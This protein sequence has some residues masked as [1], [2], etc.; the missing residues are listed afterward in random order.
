[1]PRASGLWRPAV[2]RTS[3]RFLPQPPAIPGYL[4]ATIDVRPAAARAAEAVA[5]VVAVHVDLFGVVGLDLDPHLL[6]E[7]DPD[8]P[9]GRLHLVAGHLGLGDDPGEPGGGRCRPGALVASDAA[10]QQAADGQHP[11]DE[12]ARTDHEALLVVGG[13]GSLGTMIHRTR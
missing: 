12:P 10:A 6:P 9:A 4:P 5:R 2:V 8:P 11:E 13:Y 3:T 1:M 7:V